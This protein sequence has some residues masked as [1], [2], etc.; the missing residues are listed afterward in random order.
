MKR[1]VIVLL[2]LS[3]WAA[4]A[5]VKTQTFQVSFN[6]TGTTGPYPFTFPIS[7]PTAMTVS[8]NGTLLDPT[9]YTIVPVNNNYT[10]GGSVTLHSPCAPNST[11][12]LL[13]RKT[14]ITQTL[15]FTDNMPIPMKSFESG[16]DKLTEIDQEMAYTIAQVQAIIS[17]SACPSN[18]VLQSIDPLV[19]VVNGGGGGGGGTFSPP[20]GATQFYSSAAALIGTAP[21]NASLYPGTLSGNKID[22]ACAAFSAA[23]GVVVVP[24]GMANGAS[25][26]GLPS[27]CHL[28]DYRSGSMPDPRT[29]QPTTNLTNGLLTQGSES[30]PSNLTPSTYHGFINQMFQYVAAAGGNNSYNGASGSKTDYINIAASNIFRTVGQHSGIQIATFNNT[31]GDVLPLNMYTSSVGGYGTGGDEQVVSI[32]NLVTQG[33]AG[34][35]GG[36]PASVDGLGG[37]NSGT[38]TGIN[39]STGTVTYTPI[40]NEQYMGEQRFIRDLGSKY[41]TGTYTATNVPGSPGYTQVV[42]SGTTWTSIPGFVGTHTTFN[43]AQGEILTSNLWMCFDPL[44]NNGYDWCAPVLQGTDNTHLTVIESKSGVGWGGILPFI[45]LQGGTYSLYRGAWPTNVNTYTHTFQA[46]N[47]MVPPSSG[48]CDVSGLTN[49]HTWDEVAA[50]NATFVGMR[51]GLNRSIGFPSNGGGIDIQNQSNATAPSMYCAICADGQFDNVFAFG[52]S[53][54]FGTANTVIHTDKDFLGYWFVDTVQAST[55]I[56]WLEYVDSSSAV[57]T[58]IKVNRDTSSN[59]STNIYPGLNFFGNLAHIRPD[60]T[61]DGKALYTQG[62]ITGN[63]NLNLGGFIDSSLLGT[64][65]YRNY[66]THSL[67]DTGAT[68]WPN[69]GTPPTITTNAGPDIFG[70]NTAEH[71]VISAGTNPNEQ[72]QVTGL[73]MLT[74]HTYQFSFFAQGDAGGEIFFAGLNNGDV[75]C[76]PGGGTFPSS[77]TLTTSLSYYAGT[78]TPSTNETAT[79][80]FGAVYSVSTSVGY[81]IS[82]AQV[83]EVGVDC[84]P[85]IITTTTALNGY[86][87]VLSGVPFTIGAATNLVGGALG[88]VPYQ[89]ASNA[90]GFVSPQTSG[91][92]LCLTET[93][94]G[95]VGAA[96]VWGA[97]SGT[98]ATAFSAITGSTN[99]SA[100]MLVGTG[101]SLGPTG[102]GT[103]TA[104]ALSGTPSTTLASATQDICSFTQALSTGS[105]AP[106]GWAAITATCTGATTSD[107]VRCGPAAATPTF[108][109]VTGYDATINSGN[110]VTI[111]PPYVSSANTVTIGVGSSLLNSLTFSPGSMSLKCV[112]VR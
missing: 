102:S 32:E 96:P 93:G 106:G 4:H 6:C 24:P 44:A 92:T 89:S 16:L 49:G 58:A 45:G 31:A 90:T 79:P 41:S 36:P 14:P 85:Q 29:G 109:G 38:I 94:T 28:L 82:Q 80:Y 103:V 105:I 11:L 74:G 77:W 107:I 78:C 84:G 50:Y 81:K 71:V 22:N 95:S 23:A 19:C 17:A 33:D 25:V 35:I 40:S 64:G 69:G 97:C 55:A 57:Q 12:T 68:G 111:D 9:A 60:G 86:S 30:T 66:V 47:P 73:T 13:V 3:G 83:C 34:V 100:A 67:F 56:N 48:T 65:P 10:N 2:L 5:T 108:H 51:I 43:G 21:I 8:I 99:T 54:N 46:C 87:T 63:G 88:S 26:N 104:N 61:V 72:H 62:N 20:L 110:V 52:D 75:N 37:V 27:I 18:E 39:S 112:V 91:S 7:D 76:E 101:A 98:S 59:S 15:V 1:L 53:G 70:T 42:G